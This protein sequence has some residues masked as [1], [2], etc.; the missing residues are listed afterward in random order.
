MAKTALEVIVDQHTKDIDR[1]GDGMEQMIAGINGL[2]ED[3][4]ERSE[5]YIKIQTDH[6]LEDS[7]RF[8]KLEAKMALYIG[9]GM[10]FATF[11][12][13]IITGIATTVGH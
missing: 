2:R 12:K 4:S 9:V 1:I 11:A 10:C 8:G 3:M 7:Q 13:D 5:R 6:A